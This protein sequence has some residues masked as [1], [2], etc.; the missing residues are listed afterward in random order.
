MIELE[1][2]EVGHLVELELVGHLVELDEVELVEYYELERLDRLID[3]EAVKL[4]GQ[5]LELQLEVLGQLVEV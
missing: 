5:V 2:D 4:I 3:E 1:E